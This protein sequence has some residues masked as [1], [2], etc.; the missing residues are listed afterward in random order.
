[1]AIF[2]DIAEFRQHAP[3]LHKNYDW[4]KLIVDINQVTI[5]RVLPF[6]GQAFYLHLEESYFPTNLGYYNLSGQYVSGGGEADATDAEK[7]AIR[8][9][10]TAAANFTIIHLLSTNRIQLSEMGVQESASS[11]G[12]S[13]PASFHAIQ[14]AKDQAAAVAYE[15]MEL[16]LRLLEEG[17]SDYPL[18]RSSDSYSRMKDLFTWNTEVFNYH[19]GIGSSRHTYLQLRPFLAQVQNWEL[20][21]ELGDTLTSTILD[22]LKAGT[23]TPTDQG[24]LAHLQAWQSTAAMAKAL[25]MQRVQI[26]GGSIYIRSE[27]DGPARKTGLNN[28]IING[29]TLNHLVAEYNGLAE[30]SR[31]RT[32]RYLR[33][34]AATFSYVPSD[35]KFWLDGEITDQLPDNGYNRYGIRRRSFRT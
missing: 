24:L 16:L 6:L 2:Q 29:G 32:I 20:S 4:Q 35:E 14:D 17:G 12:T 10:Q 7:S 1:M 8:L 30:L 11:D 23:L 34:H 5:L 33:E 26:K 3:Q 28:D 13:S 9:L 18:W 25:P 31:R 22:K 15:Y 27:M 21:G 19:V